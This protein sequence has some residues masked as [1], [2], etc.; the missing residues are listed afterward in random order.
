MTLET[1]PDED[2]GASSGRGRYGP[3]GNRLEAMAEQLALAGGLVLV[4]LTVFTVFSVIGR[5]V[6]NSPILG[7][8]EVTELACGLAAF[9]FLPYCQ[10]KGGNIVIDFFTATLTARV[11]A[12]LDTIHNAV[13]TGVVVIITWRLAAGGIDAWN[14]G[15]I[16]MMLQLPIWV[17]YLGA[18]AS[19]LLL[20]LCCLYGV[21]A[22]FGKV[23]R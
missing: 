10:I 2:S 5:A 7:D 4:F 21:Y 15:E 18:V 22:H 17:G 14:H 23:I 3:F 19:S 9:A 8:A 16:S 20:T 1:D 12:V 6:F 11:R 13:F